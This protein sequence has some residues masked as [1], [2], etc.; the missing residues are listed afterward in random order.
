MLSQQSK[1]L[2]VD[3]EELVRQLL[4]RLLSFSGFLV[5]EASNGAAALQAARQAGWV[6]ESGRDGPQHADHGRAGV[7][8]RAPA[9]R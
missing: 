7:R 2:L 9:Y 5:E 6:S 8:P 4:A 3:D 1:I